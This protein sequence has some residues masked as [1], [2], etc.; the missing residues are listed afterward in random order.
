MA[1]R[2][3]LLATSPL[4]VVSDLQRSIAFCRTALGFGEA[5]VWGEP[6][7]FAMLSRDGFD[8]MLSLADGEKR[9][10][11]NGSGGAWDVHLRVA[12]VGAEIATLAAAGIALAKG[13]TDTFYAM[14]EIE[15][16]DPDGHR[17]CLAQDL[18][19]AVEEWEGVLDVGGTKLR[20]VLHLH[21][22]GDEWRGSLDSPDQGAADLPIAVC[23]RDAGSLHLELPA[24]GAVYDGKVAADGAISGTWSQRGRSWPLQW[25][26][27]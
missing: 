22:A 1:P 8:L 3:R 16:L 25:K 2:S 7:C 21:G 11:P 4:L 18:G 26:R 17:F 27:R 10:Q 24:I 14:R 15:V 20:L 19:A 13:P 6:P 23:R 5:S 12:D 9:V